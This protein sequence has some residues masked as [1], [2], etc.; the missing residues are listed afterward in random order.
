MP[1]TLP[2]RMRDRAGGTRVDALVNTC[3]GLCR[4]EKMQRTTWANAARWTLGSAWSSRRRDGHFADSS[5]AS[6]IETL[7][8]G[9]GGSRL[10][11][12]PT[13]RRAARGVGGG[14]RAGQH[15]GGGAPLDCSACAA[16]AALCARR[17]RSL[18]LR[19]CATCSHGTCAVCADVSRADA[20]ER[21]VARRKHRLILLHYFHHRS[22]FQG[23]ANMIKFQCLTPFCLRQCLSAT[24]LAKTV[25]CL[26]VQQ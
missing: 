19:P 16:C 17:V 8:E 5:L 4:C 22:I 23:D 2:T 11:A 1:R 20:R 3:A 6:P 13:A 12:S 24:V 10:T 26:A 18:C 25:P 9:R 21:T 7:A 14:R 15:A